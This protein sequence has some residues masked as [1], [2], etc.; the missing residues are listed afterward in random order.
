MTDAEFWGCL[1]EMIEGAGCLPDY[2][3]YWA[4]DF[5]PGL[6]DSITS[7][8]WI[9]LIGY[10][11]SERLMLQLRRKYGAG[12]SDYEF[13]WPQDKIRPRIAACRALMRECLEM[14]L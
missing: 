11:Q 10:E 1:A 5:C 3:P 4:A 2:Q 7:A 9:D 14:G 13:Y 8:C 12:R 6:C